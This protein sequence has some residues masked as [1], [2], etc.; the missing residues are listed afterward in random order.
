[1]CPNVRFVRVCV[2]FEYDRA[3]KCDRSVC[4]LM[5]EGGSSTI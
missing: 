2:F 3:M 4:A 5:E 1:L